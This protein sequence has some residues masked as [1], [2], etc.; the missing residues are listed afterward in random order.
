MQ[1]EY[2]GMSG[3][4]SQP[5]QR[6]RRRWLRVLLI[7][8]GVVAFVV[9]LVAYLALRTPT[10]YE[11][12]PPPVTEAEKQD[13]RNLLTDAEQAF[14]H[15]LIAGK[16]FTYRIYD[17]YLNQWIAMRHEI[18]P[19]IDDSL[20]VELK[21]PFIRF[22]PGQIQLGARGQVAGIGAV[23]SVEISVA[24][25]ADEIVLQLGDI[26]CG[27]L[28]APAIPKQWREQARVDYAFGEAWRGS[29][30]LRGDLD[31]GLR[32]GAEG[33]WQNGGTRFRVTDARVSDGV[34]ELDVTPLPR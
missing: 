21:D 31:T 33:R 5:E 22:L 10:W 1:R 34:L 28:P 24:Y 30:A 14:T 19:R 8:F 26:S 3:K 32:I 11:P 2:L 7:S 12:Q 20:P 17:E 4:A 23:V 6:P 13:I 29:P 27:S 15:S 9:L 16:P 25:E 18:Y